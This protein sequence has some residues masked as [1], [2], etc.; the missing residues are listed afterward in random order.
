[1]LHQFEKVVPCS[2]R[3]E[4]LGEDLQCFQAFV[5]RVFTESRHEKV[6]QEGVHAEFCS[7]P[8]EQAETLGLIE[9]PVDGRRVSESS[10]ERRGSVQI[11]R[12]ADKAAFGSQV[13]R[14]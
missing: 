8:V 12:Q 14:S 3:L 9:E 2:L 1:M 5:D 11:R 13:T 7:I 10:S 6:A 4:V